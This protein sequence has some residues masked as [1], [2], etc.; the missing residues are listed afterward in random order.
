MNLGFGGTARLDQEKSFWYNSLGISLARV[1]AFTDS[2]DAATQS[3]TLTN[4]ALDLVSL[5]GYKFRPKL[6]I[7]AEGRWTST[8]IE[9]EDE[10]DANGIPQFSFALNSPGKATVSAGIT[11]LPIDNLVIN[12]HP[13]GYQFNWPG[14][15]SSQAGAKIGASYLAEIF[16]GIAW[17]SDLDAF[18]PYSGGGDQVLAF[19]N[20]D[21]DAGTATGL[22]NY[23]TSDLTNW[24]WINSFT[25]NIFKGIGVKFDVG[26][27]SNRQ[28]ANLNRFAASDA[29][30]VIPD[31]NPFQSYFGLGLGYSFL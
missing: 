2:E 12:V 30:T 13:L 23:S 28:I 4:N 22:V 17:K 7:S 16:P 8:L 10:L 15:L 20:E 5:Y 11:W 18:V 26:L 25:F 1:S 9:E 3:I 6:A 14:T 19:A 27:G 31:N 21:V 29:G 24:T